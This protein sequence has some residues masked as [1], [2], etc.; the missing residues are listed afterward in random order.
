[1]VDILGWDLRSEV[2]VGF[3]VGWGGWEGGR[4]VDGSGL[5][6]IGVGWVGLGLLGNGR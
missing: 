5:D 2:L 6:W 1:M 4:G 3:V